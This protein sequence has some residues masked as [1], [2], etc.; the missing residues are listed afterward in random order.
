M[1]VSDVGREAQKNA[2]PV[3]KCDVTGALGH[4]H[5]ALAKI[6]HLKQGGEGITHIAASTTTEQALALGHL[7]RLAVVRNACHL[8]RLSPRKR[9]TSQPACEKRFK[10]H[11]CQNHHRILPL[12]ESLE[13][14]P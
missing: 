3:D 8:C 9:K 11:F 1:T 13:H 10:V 2:R 6:H 14:V 5:R 12:T 4:V 7:A